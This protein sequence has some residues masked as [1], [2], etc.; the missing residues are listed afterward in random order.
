[1]FRTAPRGGMTADA[2][3]FGV[4][5]LGV[6]LTVASGSAPI[7]ETL[8]RYVLPWLPHASVDDEPADVI[9]EAQSAGDGRVE[10]RVDGA[11]ADVVPS[12]SAAVPVVQRVLD[13]ALIHQ[14]TQVAVIHG[15]VVAHGG[16]VI[17]LPGPTGAGKSTLVAELIRQGAIY[18]SDEYALIDAA[19]CVHP[20]PRALLLRDEPN[21]DR[22]VLA[23]ELGGSVACEPAI[24]ALILGLDYTAD[25]EL[26]LNALNQGEGVL[27]LLRN[28]PQAL[29]DRPWILAPLEHAVARA[30]C[31]AG[32][33]GEASEAAA[34]ILRLA[35]SGA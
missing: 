10:V 9:V 21:H 16:R 7:A 25:A 23:T 15:G 24:P 20:Y 8:D 5:I 31:Y 3:A 22:A 4:S 32:R 13:E 2:L 11:V 29:A 12:L 19:G 28:T 27:L 30:T 17:V 1:M 18:F 34:A 33:R 35:T 6:R 14:Q 26:S